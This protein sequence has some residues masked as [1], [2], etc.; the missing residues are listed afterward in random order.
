MPPM[1]GRPRRSGKREKADMK[2][3]GKLLKYC[4]GY[5]PAIIISIIFAIGGT[6]C[7]IIGPDKIKALTDEIQFGLFTEIN[8]TVIIDS[9]IALVIIYGVGAILSYGQQFIMATVTQRASKRLRSDINGKITK[10][11][12]NYFDTTSTGDILSRMTNDVDTISQTLSQSTANLV[13]A[14]V[15]FIG[16]IIMMFKVNAVLAATTIGSSLVGFVCMSVILKI[17]QKHFDAKQEQLGE[18]NGQIEEVY[19]QHNT[20]KAYNGKHAARK[21]FWAVNDKLYDSNRKS[22]FLSGIMMPVM[23]FVGNLSYVLIFVV[24]VA[25]I[26]GGNSTVTIGTLMAFVIYARLFSQPLGTIAQAMTSVQ[27]ASAASR[28]VFDM[29]EGEEMPDESNKAARLENPKGDVTF[30]NIKFGYLPDKE[31]IHGFSAQLKSGQ[32]VAIVGPT[33]AGK[34]TIVNLLMRFYDVNSGDI[35]IDGVSINDMTRENVHDLFDMILQNTWLFDGTI[36][37]NLVY[38]KQGVTDEQL[39]KVCAAVGLSHYIQCLPNGYD[40][41]I[42]ESSQLSEG[43]KQQLTIARAMIKDA[44]LLILDEATSNVDTRTELAI[45]AAMDELTKDRTSFVIAHRLSTIKNADV[46]LVLKDGDIIEQGNHET[47]LKQNGFY[48]ELYN[49]QFAG[50]AT[51]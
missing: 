45:Q 11:P 21:K 22:Q 5:L 28:R 42:G 27:Q 32:K 26:V 30:D 51:A 48:A 12:L 2:A 36:R 16:V 18:M 10:L 31:I 44:P 29:L 41:V 13:S 4:K 9:C 47:L 15:L 46:I 34:T 23:T 6:V 24:G 25:F 33:G 50:T 19:T 20:V 3:F 14:V 8:M 43:Q 37:E 7:T 49:S 1:M 40:T 38:N 35:K 17:S 39:D